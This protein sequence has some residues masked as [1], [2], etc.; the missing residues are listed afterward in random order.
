MICLKPLQAP[1]ISQWTSSGGLVLC[2]SVHSTAAK[3]GSM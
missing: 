2:R 3:L 1:T